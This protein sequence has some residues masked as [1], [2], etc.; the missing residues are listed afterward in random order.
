MS[1]SN[2]LLLTI[3]ALGAWTMVMWG[4]MYFTRI[5]ALFKMKMRLDPQAVRG[6]QMSL[7]PAQVRWKAD[8]YNHLFEQPTLFY[9]IVIVLFLLQDSSTL[10]LYLAWSY[11]LIRILHSLVQATIN[12]IELRFTL[13]VLSSLCLIGLI[14]KSVM[15]WF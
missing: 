9:A 2:S 14:L 11:V 15:F 7:L 4:W 13:F 10:A 12:K 5:P 3:I 8:N 1:T 6:E